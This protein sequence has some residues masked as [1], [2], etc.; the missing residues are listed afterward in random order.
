MHEKIER[1]TIS[2]VLIVKN[3]EH[4]IERVLGSLNWVDEIV[5]VDGKSTDRTCELAQKYTN[6][7]I[8]HAFNGS[9]S[10]DRKIGAQAA[11][12]DWILHMDADEEVTSH[13]KEKV[14]TILANDSH[15][16]AGFKFYRKNWFLGHRMDWGGWRHQI[17]MMH[18]KDKA[19]IHGRTHHEIKVNGRIGLIDSDIHHYP[20]SSLSQ[21]IDRHNRYSSYNCD[22]I[23][24]KNGL[25][26]LREIKYHLT[27]RPLKLFIKF[28]IRKKGYRDGMH[29]LVFSIL[30]AFQHFLE[31]AKYWEKY[32]DQLPEKEKI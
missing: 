28:Y 23:K 6:K 12:S 10:E 13:F 15:H 4:Q 30:F 9:W 19:T 11:E 7:I 3:E 24:E 32:K 22:E 1:E 25:L 31:W 16:Y 21:F 26:P 14:L 2:A 20:F 29:G 18:R 17:L 8:V 5:I 27:W